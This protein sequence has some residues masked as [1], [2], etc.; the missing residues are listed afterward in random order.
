[1]T[2]THVR[3]RTEEKVIG[4]Y[5]IANFSVEAIAQQSADP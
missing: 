4:I 3:T 1:M 2:G 5:T